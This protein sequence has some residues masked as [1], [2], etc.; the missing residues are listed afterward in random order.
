MFLSTDQTARGF[1][2]GVLVTV[3][4]DTVVFLL[5]GREFFPCA[6]R[7]LII[8]ETQN[9]YRNLKRIFVGNIHLLWDR[10]GVVVKVL[11]Y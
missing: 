3:Q 1:K 9:S 7:N 2:H 11:R 6:Q 10:D 5:S 4:A 8:P